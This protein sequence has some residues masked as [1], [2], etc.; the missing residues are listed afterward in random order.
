MLCILNG[1]IFFKEFADL[2][3]KGKVFF[4]LG[5]LIVLS[6]MGLLIPKPPKSAGGPG[7]SL[8]Q[9]T[10]ASID[11]S[12]G[13]S[14]PPSPAGGVGPTGLPSPESSAAP[15]LDGTA[16]AV[17]FTGAHIEGATSIPG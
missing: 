8:K 16:R 7:S 4:V 17:T 2:P 13:G 14:V 1:G 9:R 11:G 6:G 3:E 12:V 10:A 5:L 15:S